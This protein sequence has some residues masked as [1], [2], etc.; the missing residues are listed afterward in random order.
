MPLP[1][2]QLSL[3][4]PQ[5]R[6]QHGPVNAGPTLNASPGSQVACTPVPFLVSARQP[7]GLMGS[8]CGVWQSLRLQLSTT[9]INEEMRLKTKLHTFAFFVVG[10]FIWGSALC[11]GLQ[12]CH[13]PGIQR[14]L[15]SP[16]IALCPGQHWHAAAACAAA[17]TLPVTGLAAPISAPHAL[18]ALC[19]VP[20]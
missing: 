9:L 5:A 17:A 16:H 20:L 11:N 4:R 1:T 6:P 10:G 15:C 14:G 2:A 13:G 3:P 18:T 8:C 19:N 12:P 7:C